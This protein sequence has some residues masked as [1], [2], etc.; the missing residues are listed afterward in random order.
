MIKV[1]RSAFLMRIFTL[2]FILRKQMSYN[3]DIRNKINSNLTFQSAG[4]SAGRKLSEELTSNLTK[5]QRIL[6][7]I[8]DLK[9]GDSGLSHSRFAQATLTNWFPKAV[10]SRGVADL[11]EV[12]FLE[13]FEGALFFYL[14]SLM[15]EYLSRRKIFGKTLPKELEKDLS[16][17][18]K[19]ILKQGHKDAQKLLP[20]KAAIVLSCALIPAAEY[21]LSF[22]K[23]LFTLKV[24]KQ[25]DFTSIANLDKT[26]SGEEKSKQE[27]V[28]K[29]AKSHLKKA[30]IFSLCAF[31]LSLVLGT[32]GQKSKAIAKAC[33]YFLNPGRK[34]YNGLE[35]LGVKSP[36]L[37]KFLDKYL[38]LDF[39]RKSDGSL[40]L[41]NGQLAV[42][43]ISGVFGYFGAAHDR[44]KLDVQEVA[45]RL[46]I[47]ATYTIFGSTL[48]DEGFK[49]ILHSDRKYPEILKQDKKTKEFWTAS[50]NDIP[51][52]AKESVGNDSKLLKGKI[53]EL[54]KGKAKIALVPFLFTL[55]VVGALLSLVSR[56]LTQY[57]YNHQEAQPAKQN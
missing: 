8:I 43:V 16:K 55:G 20:A 11:S 17:P 18:V 51:Q 26:K 45:T 34:I 42:T 14:P 33:E 49:K 15:G 5:K 52:I 46:P 57:R 56:I 4:S 27:R 7:K 44:G 3:Y 48:F 24:F 37:E 53:Q 9:E 40:A 36:K 1:T 19:D 38:N 28:E 22:A 41:G 23:N 21:A 29:S 6:A 30:G 54:F 32:A 50:L 39:A 31:G 47:I 10:F 2:E 25:A 12:T 13:L 35:R